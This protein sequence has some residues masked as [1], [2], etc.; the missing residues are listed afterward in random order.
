MKRLRR[1][2]SLEWE[3]FLDLVTAQ[4][5]LL[6]AWWT[7]QRRPKGELLRRVQA[8][9]SAGGA[10]DERRL[11]RLAVAVDRVS[12]FGVFR[13]TCQIGRAHV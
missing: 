11:A 12:R 5:S 2:R 10:L 8:P 9:A 6:A 13:P 1:L 4:R 7:V 3:E